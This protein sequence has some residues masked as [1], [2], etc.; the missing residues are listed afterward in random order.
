MVLLLNSFAGTSQQQKI[1]DP[2][3]LA[4]FNI[5]ELQLQWA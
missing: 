4:I 5:D 3:E 1:V 2:D